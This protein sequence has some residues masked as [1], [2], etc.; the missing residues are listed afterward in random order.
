MQL[1]RQRSD[2][3]QILVE[4]LL[5]RISMGPEPEHSVPGQQHEGALGEPLSRQQAEHDR[6]PKRPAAEDDRCTL[7]RSVPRWFAQHE[8]AAAKATPCFA[9]GCLRPQPPSEFV[10]VRS[11]GHVAAAATCAQIPVHTLNLAP[12]S[13]ATVARSA[14]QADRPEVAGYV[15]G[16]V[17][18]PWR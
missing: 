4:C 7:G 8:V 11:V 3:G 14:R 13:K 2:E 17:S 12:R 6:V 10:L 18:W 1:L 9:Y 5:D 16:P 15:Q